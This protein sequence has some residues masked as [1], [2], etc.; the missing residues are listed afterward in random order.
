LKTYLALLVVLSLAA[1]PHTAGAIPITIQNASFEAPATATVVNSID[2]WTIGGNGAGVWNINNFPAGF[3]NETAPDG[4][5]IAFV[6]RT[7]LNGGLF[8]AEIS[9]ILTATLA[10]NSIYT[11]SW[12]AGH[13]IGFRT[14]TVGT[15]ELRAGGVLLVAEV[16]TGP[17][18]TFDPFDVVFDSTTLGPVSPL[19]GQQLEIRFTTNKAQTGFDQI[20]LDVQQAVPEP[21]TLLLLGSGIV[22][23]G[24]VWRKRRPR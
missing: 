21:S 15:A 8:P 4:N 9:Q 14:G 22:G 5:Q 20:A 18:G 3:W 6:G 1:V 10:P 23:L 17:E 2:N 16:G 7:D 13:P 19:F 24:T 12:E 11:L